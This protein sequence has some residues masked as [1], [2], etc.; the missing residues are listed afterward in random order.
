MSEALET[1]GVDPVVLSA[2]AHDGVAVGDATCATSCS[3]IRAPSCSEPVASVLA[4]L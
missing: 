3:A 4:R 1:A 2:E